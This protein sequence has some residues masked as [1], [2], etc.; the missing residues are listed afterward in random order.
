MNGKEK[1]ITHMLERPDLPPNYVAICEGIIADVGL[2]DPSYNEQLADIREVARGFSEIVTT[3]F[4]ELSADPDSFSFHDRLT[5]DPALRV[6]ITPPDAIYRGLKHPVWRVIINQGTTIYQNTTPKEQWDYIDILVQPGEYRIG[7]NRRRGV[8]ELGYRDL[9][10]EQ[11]M[12]PRII[13]EA[14]LPKPQ[15]LLRHAPGYSNSMPEVPLFG[16]ASRMGFYRAYVINAANMLG[17]LGL[18]SDDTRV[19]P[20]PNLLRDEGS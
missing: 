1:I 5:T 13:Q 4:E 9:T 7:V 14:T 18:L 17:T 11:G 3:R 6:A 20:S 12:P 19:E 16:K 2:V 8:Y 15:Y 10:P